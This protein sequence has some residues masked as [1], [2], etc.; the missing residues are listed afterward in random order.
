MSA[1]GRTDR[2]VLAVVA[3]FTLLAGVARYGGWDSIV[4]FVFALF[5]LTTLK[6][7]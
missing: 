5:S 1:L 4:A 6:L 2:I 7:R 3:V